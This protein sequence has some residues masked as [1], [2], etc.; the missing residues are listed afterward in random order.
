MA[1]IETKNLTFSYP[2][3]GVNALKDISIRVNEGEFVLL[4]GRSGS[5]KSTL[6]RLLKNEIA[7]YG[8]LNGSIESS[9][10]ESAFVVQNTDSSFVSQNV[11]GELVFALEN[12]G[13]NN[14]KIAVK[15]GE[16]ASFFNLTDLLDADI[17]TLSGGERA[18]VAVAAAMIS[19]PKLLILDEPLSQ[20]DPKASSQL[21]SLLKRVN[22]ELGTTIIMS[23]H[24][25]D[26]VVDICDKMLVLEKGKLIAD[27]KPNELAKNDRLL[28]F[29]PI[30][31]SLY[32]S[33]P[34][35]VKDAVLCHGNFKEKELTVNEFKEK[36]IELKN[37]VF[38]YGKNERDILDRLSM[39]VFKGS[40]HSVIGANGS[41]KTTLLKVIAGIK[42]QYSGKVKLNGKVAYLPQNPQYLFTKDTVLEE[43][44]QSS[45]KALCPN[46][47]KT[48]HPY[49]LS[50]GEMQKLAI[51][52]LLKND[53]DIILMDEPT[54]SLDYFSKQELKKIIN[55][56][57]TQGKTVVIVSHDL[58]FVGE[59]SD[60]VSF[61]SDGI[62]TITGDRRTVFS[63]LDFYTTQIRRVT[64][65]SLSLAVAPEDIV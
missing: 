15:L 31:T 63:S 58:D 61:L 40:V 13:L 1:Y 34:L 30:Y 52:I 33:R 2:E 44:G 9:F 20:L 53:F 29:F 59:V 35:T 39:T 41:G 8:N 54:K 46:D 10:A 3:V 38:A 42:K 48:R 12:K 22:D 32:D 50:G 64:K 57:I 27:G 26:R 24:I 6:L 25:S 51:E 19:S 21:V 37:I 11:R 23:S 7:P 18:T 62:I 16:T 45:A 60:F 65:S 14:D 4:M 36:A 28:L 17:S 56:L 49:D 5:G 47:Y 43:V 55:S